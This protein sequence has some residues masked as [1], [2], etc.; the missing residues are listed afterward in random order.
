[1]SI[2]FSHGPLCYQLIDGST[3]P[4]LRAGL[5]IALAAAGWAR[6]RSVTNGYVYGS[7]SPQGL[8][9]KLLVQ[10]Q[11]R[12]YLGKGYINLQWMSGD[13]ARAGYAHELIYASGRSYQAVANRCQLFVSLPG[14]SDQKAPD[15]GYAHTVAGGTLFIPDNPLAECFAE[16]SEEGAWEAWWSCGSGLGPF[17]VFENFRTGYRPQ[18][19]WSASFNGDLMVEDQKDL[20]PYEPAN[21]LRLI[22]IGVPRPDWGILPSNSR[23]V[24]FDEEPLWLDPL[25]AWG[26]GAQRDGI[27]RI[28]GQIWD[29]MLA[30]CDRPLDSEVVTLEDGQ[31]MR[32]INFSHSTGDMQR[33]APGTYYG[34][35]HLLKSGPGVAGL[36]NY[37][38]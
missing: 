16:G 33:G 35:L 30:S 21:R 27:A 37:A 20:P 15:G 13:E 12:H 36:A 34:S 29:A 28:R 9:S 19:R 26:T 3:S 11:D 2:A 38:Y 24:L 5:D 31:E 8:P 14:I 7:L 25:V 4:D 10:D 32:W 18:R 22:P 17:D 23:S 6:V 1:M